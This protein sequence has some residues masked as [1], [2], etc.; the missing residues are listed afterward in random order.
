V[1]DLRAEDLAVEED[2]VQQ[3]ISHFA[4]E[5]NIE[6]SIGILIDNRRDFS[7]VPVDWISPAFIPAALQ[8]TREFLK[9]TRPGDEI[10]L[11]SFH[12]SVEIEE[13]FTD[14]QAR[15]EAR[16]NRIRATPSS[17]CK[18][19]GCD[20]VRSKLNLIQA[21]DAALQKM[22]N[23]KHRK[24]ALLVLTAA[25]NHSHLNGTPTELAELGT[26]IRNADV[27]VFGFGWQQSFE[28]G[29]RQVP[30]SASPRPL[31]SEV[32]DSFASE[33]GGRSLIVKSAYSPSLDLME[34][35]LHSIST[36]LHSHYRIGYYPE[37]R[38]SANP[39]INI[40]PTSTEY[41]IH[42]W[43]DTGDSGLKH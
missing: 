40:R 10:L 6:T 19:V 24:R 35:F 3:T 28:V 22:G 20:D 14:N 9:M 13:A 18:R 42:A 4:L 11:M 38:T 27:G 31:L 36:E 21:V 8:A 37:K 12:N 1:K 30:L 2:G 29:W 23:S 32:L 43:R 41:R 33:S 17:A 25:N 16:L 34:A 5:S 39:S 15:I 7:D 26:R